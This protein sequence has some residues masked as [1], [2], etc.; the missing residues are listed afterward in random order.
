MRVTQRKGGKP[1]MPW[2]QSCRFSRKTNSTAAVATRL[3]AFVSHEAS[4]HG[5][6]QRASGGAVIECRHWW[7][8]VISTGDIFWSDICRRAVAEN[9]TSSA[10]PQ[11]LLGAILMFRKLSRT[12]TEGQA[13]Q[14]KRRQRTDLPECHSQSM[15]YGCQQ[16]SGSI[17]HDR[18]RPQRRIQW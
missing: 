16:S 7:P 13:S 10:P 17:L 1:M 12:K 9:Q 8:L 2:F 5:F 11:L 18:A 3:L 15:K 14:K 4:C 6:F